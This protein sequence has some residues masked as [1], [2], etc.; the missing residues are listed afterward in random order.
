MNRLRDDRGGILVLSAVAIPVFLLVAALIVDV[1]N[2]YVHKRQLQNRADAA[3]LAAGVQYASSWPACITNTTDQNAIR[4]VARQFAGDPAATSPVNTEIANQSRVDV[5]LNSTSYT[6]GTDDSDGGGPC[7]DHP[8]NTS[9][10][11][12]SNI[13]PS[14]GYWTD[15]KVKERNVGT[16]F[17]GF[18]LNLLQTTARARVELKEAASGVEFIPIAVPEQT[19]V[20][21]QVRFINECNGS[22]IG[23]SVELKPLKTAYQTQG[24]M[25]LWGPDPLGNQTSVDP[26]QI[27]LTTPQESAIPIPAPAT[28]SPPCNSG[29]R[30]D[31]IPIGVEVRVAGRKDINLDPP[32]TARCTALQPATSADCFQRISEIRVYRPDNGLFGDRPQIRDVTFSPSGTSPC[33][34]DPYYTR[35]TPGAANCTFDASVFMDWGSRPLAPDGEFEATIQV[36][37]GTPRSLAGSAPQGPW[38]ASGIPISSLGP[39]D[40]TVNW[41]YTLKNKKDWAPGSMTNCNP[42]VRSGSTVVH[43]VNLADDPTGANDPPSGP[44]AAV[45]LTYGPTLTSAELHSAE[46]NTTI[47]PY[48]TIG[49]KNAFQMGDF[50]ILR[51][52]AG[53]QNFSIICDPYWGQPSAQDTSAAFYFGCQP[54]YASN[55]TTT[56]SYWWSTSTGCPDW[57]NWFSFSGTPP[58]VSYPNSPWRCLHLQPGGKGQTIGDGIAMRTKNCQT[59]VVTGPPGPGVKADCQASK[60]KCNYG[61]RWNPGDPPPSSSDPRVVRLFVVPYGAYKDVANGNN[62]DIPVLQLAAFY[63]TGWKYNKN[64]DPCD[65]VGDGAISPALYP[66][67]NDKLGD[68]ELAGYFIKLVD[69]SGPV[70]PSR[71]CNSND[72]TICRPALTR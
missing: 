14:G 44:V 7:F 4:A 36:G 1:G 71:N 43:R 65:D 57:S 64:G 62:A 61:V 11:N 23:N 69:S 9:P 29:N 39:V 63:I 17:G 26:G 5:M 12:E 24:G 53:Q 45:K 15:V 58:N 34:L 52:R 2:W 55:D 50:A 10:E 33:A 18:G 32:T 20:K 31:Y 37:S 49:L 70:D 3:A 66:N 56:P 42:C 54:P 51:Q 19:V 41:K 27:A 25:Q 59:P 16:I 68:E 38:V 67:D 22:Q 8:S 30:L 40:V 21:A 28:G 6:A 60:Y 47:S 46:T 35:L 13:T 48:V 72:V